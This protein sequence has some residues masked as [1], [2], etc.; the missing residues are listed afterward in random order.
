M[1]LHEKRIIFFKINVYTTCDKECV[2]AICVP[3]P[4]R[5]YYTSNESLLNKLSFNI[6]YVLMY[7]RT[8]LTRSDELCVLRCDVIKAVW[9]L[10]SVAILCHVIFLY[11]IWI[12]RTW[13]VKWHLVEVDR[14]KYDQVMAI[15]PSGCEAMDRRRKKLRL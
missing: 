3:N 15:Y 5:F 11:T 2:M 4:I 7:T 6:K 8:H 13:R 1:W 10:F 12:R 14:S 9:C